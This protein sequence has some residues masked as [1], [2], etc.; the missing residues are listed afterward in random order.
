MTNAIP[1][2]STPITDPSSLQAPKPI[3]EFDENT[4]VITITSPGGVVHTITPAT[5]D[6]LE[7]MP[8]IFKFFQKQLEN[9]PTKIMEY[10]KDQAGDVEGGGRRLSAPYEFKCIFDPSTGVLNF[11]SKLRD[12]KDAKWDIRPLETKSNSVAMQVLKP[13]EALASVSVT[14]VNPKVAAV[15][16][17]IE[18]FNK[19]IERLNKF[20]E[21]VE[22]GVLKEPPL[23][24]EEL[25]ETVSK[26]CGVLQTSFKS[27]KAEHAALEPSEQDQS[28]IDKCAASYQQ[29]LGRLHKLI[30]DEE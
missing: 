30:P 8:A 26:D 22:K 6:M 1:P 27:L 11:F 5:D 4:R 2:S 3:A 19:E 7:H 28:K 9:N 23:S 29:V 12:N 25:S 15:K 24:P 17:Q 13:E 14:A 20:A 10:V 18:A 16:T 21:D